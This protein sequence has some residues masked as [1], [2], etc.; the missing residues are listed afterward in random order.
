MFVCVVQAVDGIRGFCLSRG[1]GGGYKRQVELSVNII[2]GMGGVG[3][4]ERNG[5]EW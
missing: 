1:R 5:L 4:S 2:G 3:W